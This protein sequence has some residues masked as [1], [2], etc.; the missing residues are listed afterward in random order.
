MQH[1]VDRTR[2]YWNFPSV[3][4]SCNLIYTSSPHP[5]YPSCCVH[6]S[7]ETL[8][9][10]FAAHAVKHR[11]FQISRVPC[12]CKTILLLYVIYT[13]ILHPVLITNSLQHVQQVLVENIHLHLYYTYDRLYSVHGKPMT[14]TSTHV[15]HTMNS[16]SSVFVRRSLISAA[17]PHLTPKSISMEVSDTAKERIGRQMRNA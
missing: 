3:A 8:L 17:E 10:Y 14:I 15:T 5:S 1:T 11:S 9:Q 16:N 12:F 6:Q 2:R 13:G 7:V 4:I